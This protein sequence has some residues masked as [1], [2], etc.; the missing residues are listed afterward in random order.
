[1]TA[2]SRSFRLAVS[3]AAVVAALGIIAARLCQLALVDGDRLTEIAHRQHL[4]QEE[5]MPVRGAIFDRGGEPLAISI[6]ADSIFL[7]PREFAADARGLVLARAL[8]LSSDQWGRKLASRSPFVWIKRHADPRD[9]AALRDLAL[10]GVGTVP[11]RR[12]L[13]PQRRIAAPVVGLAGIDSQGLEGVE[14]V[15]DAYL[16]GEPRIVGVERDALGRRIA[17]ANGD[18]PPRGADVELTLDL[19]LQY[20]AERELER[21]VE[22]TRALGGLVLALDPWTGE[23]LTLAQSPSFDPNRPGSA[24]PAE[25]R[26]RAVADAFEPGST[27]KGMLAAAA[28]EE[29]VVSIRESIFCE[30]GR[31]HVGRRTIHDH[32]PYGLLSLPRVFQVSSN[33]GAAKIGERLGAERYEKYLRAFG[34]GT[35][36]GID[37]PGEQPGMLRRAAEWRAIDLATASFGHGVAVTPLQLATAYAAVANGGLLLRPYVVSRVTSES[38]RTLVQ[39]RPVTVRRVLSEETAHTVTSILEGVVSADGTGERAAIRGL[40]VAGKTGTAQKVDVEHGGYTNGRIASFVG[41][42]PV[43]RPR[44]VI[45][46]V[47]DEPRTEVYGG[48]VAAPLFREVALAAVERFHIVAPEGALAE[49]RVIEAAASVPVEA[50]AN[51]ESDTSYVGLSLREAL[52]RARHQGL[53]VELSGSG[54]VVSQDP[55]AGFAPGEA[56]VLRLALGNGEARTR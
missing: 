3:M 50:G 35:R 19:P 33:I 52:G 12:R 42:F 47:L 2:R 25:R 41:Y 40:R 34:F 49:G 14:L 22:E 10:P 7:R 31:Y 11:E 1:M 9:L 17:R 43:E 16:R 30:E 6:G 45:L 32:H 53:A 44:V 20:V 18:G 23:V 54:Y 36:T 26:L 51:L 8:G 46:A 21:Q 24:A 39:N 37:L 29:G 27:M 15:Y 55:P 28:I 13:Y 5:L 56:R 4:K 48:L 38:G